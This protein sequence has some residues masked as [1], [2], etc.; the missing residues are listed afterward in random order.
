MSIKIAI[1]GRPNVGKSTLFNRLAG[2]KLALV[3]D[4]PGLTRDR[5]EFKVEMGDIAFTIID[6]AGLEK[7][8]NETLEKFMME[9]TE[10]AMNEADIILMMIDGRQ[11]VTTLDRFFSSMVRK[12]NKPVI[13]VVNKCESNKS[14]QGFD[15]SYSLGLGEPVAISAEHNQGMAD[16]YETITSTIKENSLNAEIEENEK[17]PDLHLAIIGR[18][19]V[20][21]STLF[22]RLLGEK[23]SITG[24][25]AG[26]TR[27]SIYVDWEYKGTTIRLVDTAGMRRKSKLRHERLEKMAVH[28]S[29]HAVQYANVVVLIIDATEGLDKQDLTLA[30]HVIAEGRGLIIAVN[31]WDLVKDKKQTLHELREKL[32]YTLSQAKGVPLVALSALKGNNVKKVIDESLIIL[33]LWNK[34][35]GTGPLN[36]WLSEALEQHNPPLSG[37]KRIKFRYV[38]QIKT[39]PPTFVLFTSSS[40]KEL[41]ESYL[42]Y[43]TNSLRE[44]FKFQG[45]PIRL[46]LKKT[47]NP[48]N[49]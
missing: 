22:N 19:N 6:T 33:D 41:P 48:F 26:I 1:I 39:R 15:E 46:S 2:K 30:D 10:I 40:L 35:I 16:L 28:E 27:D 42:R 37:G 13:V 4:T 31:K 24:P 17:K 29:M 43:L 34:R 9:Q 49:G 5:R 3:D 21:K 8:E 36:R 14:S 20:G 32:E 18:P 7:A 25:I 47:S 11:G 44:K 45:V 23:R 12:K 38:T